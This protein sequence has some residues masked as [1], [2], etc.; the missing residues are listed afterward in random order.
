MRKCALVAILAFA[1][2]GLLS[3]GGGKSKSTAP[4]WALLMLAEIN[5]HRPGDELIYDA[6]IA[7]VA[8]AHA[9]WLDSNIGAYQ[10][11]GIGG[12][13]P[14]QR[15]NNAG[16]SDFTPPAGETGCYIIGS[17]QTA[18]SSMNT[19]TLTNSSYT[20]VGIGHHL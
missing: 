16:I 13:T 5:S 7:G 10:S 17:V 4:N 11:T 14:T 8:L 20:H 9:Q 2:A 15:L 18:Y 1:S 12:T 6:A 3:C 19:G